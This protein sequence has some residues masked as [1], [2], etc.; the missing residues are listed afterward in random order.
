MVKKTSKSKNFHLISPQ[1]QLRYDFFKTY[2]S[3]LSLS[4]M[5]ENNLITPVMRNTTMFFNDVNTSYK[6]LFGNS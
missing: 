4:R 5:Q 3:N 1:E 2:D 6:V